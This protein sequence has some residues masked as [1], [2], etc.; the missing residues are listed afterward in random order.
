MATNDELKK[1]S[2]L[3]KDQVTEVGFLDNAFKTLSATI[4]SAIDSA[5]D[6]MSG[7]DDITQKVAKSYQRDITNSIN[8]ATKG[9]EDQI[10]LT[11]KIQKGQNVGKELTSKIERNE[12]R[13][14][15]TL[16]KIDKL[17][18]VSRAN[19][20]KML[21]TANDVFKA[22]EASL[23]KLLEQNDANQKNKSLLQIAKENAGG[24]LDKMDKTG[25]ASKLLSG[26]LGSVLTTA[27]LLELAVLGVFKAM[28]SVDKMNGELAKG[29]NMSY[30]NAAALSSELS[31]AANMSGAV[32]LTAE[33]L[34]KALLAVND[35]TG[36]FTTENSKNLETFQELHKASGLTYE[37]MGGIYSITQATG[38]D[39]KKNTKEVLA[40]SAL[41]ANSL[42]VQINSKKV[43]ADIG[44]I[45][46]ATT[47]S[48]GSSAAELSKA[49]TTSQALGIEM[50]QMENIADGLL[51]FEQSIANEM[52]AEM[53]TG[54]SLNLEKARQLALDNDIAGAAAEIAKQ[55]GTAAEFGAMNRIQQEALAKA[56]GLSREELANSL[57]VQEQ[58]ANSVGSEYEDKKKIIDE[59]QAKG[60]SQDQIKAKLGKESLADLK[61]QSSVQEDLN[62]SVAKMKEVFVSIAAPLMQIITPIVDLLLPAVGALGYA[63]ELISAPIKII[64]DGIK[65]FVDGLKQ[66][67]EISYAILGFTSTILLLKKKEGKQ[68][69]LQM[70]I[71]KANNAYLATRSAILGVI[72]SIK[73][74][75]L[76][77]DIKG[78]AMVAFRAM[79]GIPVIGPALGIAAA[80]AALAYGYK[81]YNA[82]DM[83]SPGGGGG[84]GYGSRTL[85]GPEGAIAL[86]NKDTVIA[87]TNL[88]PKEGKQS[89]QAVSAQISM[90][91][92]EELQSS[93]NAILDN[94][95]NKQGTVSMDSTEVGT[96]FAVNTYQVQ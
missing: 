74:K 10:D 47:L 73:R 14:Q 88:F 58:L 69:L 60:L 81:L 66:A 84:A 27:R 64:G 31:T 25:T 8:K 49:L 67:S 3:L 62:K 13:R 79:G 17:E 42:G 76:L 15:L 96:S 75:T 82:D 65:M 83:M 61:A 11:I 72:K 21:G 9:L 51:N 2:D 22:E 45:S 86:N 20:N 44:K 5:I 4:T 28:I 92:L 29:L 77:E 36:V 90:A 89:Q 59:L 33:G 63:F 78:M 23:Q 94:I 7:L 19:K 48:L 95:L 80:A 68:S 87:G 85:M 30:S 1:G 71:E 39:L 54:K 16:E 46:K 24:L 53:L 91:R 56:T 55:V 38:G 52:E 34:G 12:A 50:G 70:G 26:G 37:Q 35:I 43:L 93:T 6:D 41:T 40:Q 32:K 18:G 57:F